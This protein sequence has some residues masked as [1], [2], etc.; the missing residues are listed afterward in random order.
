V[1]RRQADALL[2][3]THEANRNRPTRR[4]RAISPISAPEYCALRLMQE[5]A[6]RRGLPNACYHRV[7]QRRQFRFAL[8]LVSKA[9]TGAP[10]EL[11]SV[12]IMSRSDPFE[13]IEV[14]VG[15]RDRGLHASKYNRL[16]PVWH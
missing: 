9:T 6:V 10:E 3:P 8:K 2:V 15:N 14:A 5:E 11:G 13:V 16:Y 1:R 12:H 7:R 4:R